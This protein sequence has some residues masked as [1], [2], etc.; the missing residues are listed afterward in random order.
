[1]TVYTA[2][3]R[4]INVGGK[5]IIRMSELK[6]AFKAMGFI[7]VQTYIQS[8]N[9]IFK[10]DEGEEFLR[11][12]IE[13]EIVKVFG[14][15]VTV[16]LRTLQELE[17]MIQNCPFPEGESAEVYV[18]LLMDVPSKDNIDKLSA[19]RSENED[20]R[21]LGRDLFLLLH[22]GIRDSK[23]INNLQKLDVSST[24]RNWKTINKLINL[25]K[26]MDI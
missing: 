18:S 26:A 8:G 22:H 9:V 15:S 24:V 14:F 5:N 16:I 21:I 1:M 3:L 12:K 10:S 25:A 17:L 19:Y 11:R 23:L 20:Y 4:G 2:F 7:E 6:Q 13:Y